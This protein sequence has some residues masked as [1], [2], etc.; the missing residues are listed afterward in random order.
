MI[1]KVQ[2][3]NAPGCIVRVLTAHPLLRAAVTCH[4]AIWGPIDA[5]RQHRYTPISSFVESTLM[6]TYRKREFETDGGRPRAFTR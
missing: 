6:V 2:V 3:F 4:I 1:L 5:L